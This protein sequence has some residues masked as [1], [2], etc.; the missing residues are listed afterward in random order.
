MLRIPPSHLIFRYTVEPDSGVILHKEPWIR[1]PESDGLPDGMTVDAAGYLWSCHW[2]GARITRYDPAGQVERMLR[3][4]ATHVTSCCF[5][6]PGLDTLF[7]TT[8]RF[9]LSRDDLARY[10]LSGA[11]LALKTPCSGFASV[12]F[13]RERLQSNIMMTDKTNCLLLEQITATS[14]NVSIDLTHD[15]P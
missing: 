7:I 15:R 3:I 1:V 9:N 4:P 10:P 11:L 12:P 8:S 2:A 6:G 5:G 14:S 13:N